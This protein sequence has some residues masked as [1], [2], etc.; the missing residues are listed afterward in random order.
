MIC[1]ELCECLFV[2]IIYCSRMV[3][4]FV[5]L[6]QNIPQIWNIF[7]CFFQLIKVD[8][9]LGWANEQLPVAESVIIISVQERHY[10]VR[11]KESGNV[12]ARARDK[13]V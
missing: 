1:D 10:Y 6:Q 11:L 7:V 5:K 12:E 4:V 3:V 2:E 9:F 13:T 8:I